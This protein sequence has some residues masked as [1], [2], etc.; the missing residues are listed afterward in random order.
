MT[1]P[2]T[3]PQFP[4]DPADILEAAAD[5]LETKGWIQGRSKNENGYCAM[6]AISEASGHNYH[7]ILATLPVIE[8]WAAALVH[9]NDQETRTADQVIDLMKHAAKDLRN[10]KEPV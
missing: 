5:L 10:R 9:W 1:Q 2:S 7:R 4:I 6:G 8:M 3:S